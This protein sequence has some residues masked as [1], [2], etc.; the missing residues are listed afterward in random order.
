MDK[1]IKEVLK[2]GAIKNISQHRDQYA[3]NQFLNYLF[4][5][6]KKDRGYRPVINLKTLNQFVP[7]IQFKTES[8][9]TLKYMMKERDYMCKVDLKDAFL[10][11]L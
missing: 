1:E 11:C 4:L 3:Q 6:R 8:F 10:Q 9:K 2:K 7:Y 5:V